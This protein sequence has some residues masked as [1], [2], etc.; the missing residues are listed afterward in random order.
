MFR[1]SVVSDTTGHLVA[2]FKEIVPLQSDKLDRRKSQTLD[3]FAK[4]SAKSLA[5]FYK[6]ARAESEKNKLG[7]IGRARVA[8][9]LQQHLLAAGYS[10]TLVKQVLFAMLATS[11]TGG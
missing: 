9:G 5:E 1:S 8:F 6:V 3:D 4:T 2:A 11:F 10:P 7:V